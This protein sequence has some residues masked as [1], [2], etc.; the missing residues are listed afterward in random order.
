MLITPDNTWSGPAPGSWCAALSLL[1]PSP[2]TWLDAR[3]VLHEPHEE[4]DIASGNATQ[5]TRG[6]E[7]FHPQY[8][9][10]NQ[11]RPGKSIPMLRFKAKQTMEAPKNGV[12]ATQIVVSLD[13]DPTFGSFQYS[14]VSTNIFFLGQGYLKF[15]VVEALQKRYYL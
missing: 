10:S 4:E 9:C 3:L 2:P 14:Y 6:K 7:R 11:N 8:L 1:E 15:F 13:D 5:L 12:P